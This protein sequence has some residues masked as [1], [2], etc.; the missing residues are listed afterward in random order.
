M[1][2]DQMNRTFTKYDG[3]AYLYLYQELSKNNDNKILYSNGQQTK[4]IG[5]L[6]KISLVFQRNHA[7][8]TYC[9]SCDKDIVKV[10][11]GRFM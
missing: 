9:L 3:W 2:L 8:P 6:F 4:G 1:L 10:M 7:M 5:L 11:H